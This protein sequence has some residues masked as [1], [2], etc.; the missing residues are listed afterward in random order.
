MA[1][2]LELPL[3]TL[4]LLMVASLV[5]GWVDAVVG[6]GGLIQLP[7]LLI[8]L[9]ADTPVA[10]I[11]GTNKL[12]SS[13]GTATAA[14]TYART[15]RIDWAL[16]WPLLATA[17][18]GSWTGAQLT[19]FLAR[20]SFTPL[21]LLAVVVVGVHTWRRPHLGRHSAVR[22]AGADALLRMGAIGLAVGLWD[23]FVG[24]G[25][26][27]FFVIALVTVIGHDFLGASALAKVANL[28]TN[29]AALLAFGLGGHIEWRLGLLMAVANV[30]G[31]FLGAR[32]ALR[33]GNRFVRVVFLVVVGALA[34][35]LTVD[36]VALWL[37]R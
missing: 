15:I 19:R 21:V 33:R 22:H 32:T 4:V 17:A 28:T 8:G 23:G 3:L 30:T 36:S 7:A 13:F 35:K 1:G 6:G 18:I 26:G 5:A 25:T 9:P 29:A 27:T 31:G 2:G 10:T 12:P 20:E 16:A 14:L 37:A 34:I 24:P 11:A